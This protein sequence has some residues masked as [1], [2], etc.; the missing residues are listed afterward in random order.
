MSVRVKPKLYWLKKLAC[1]NIN[2]KKINKPTT[3]T[4]YNLRQKNFVKK[5]NKTTFHTP[6]YD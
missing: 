2:A 4:W 6:E 3:K 5:S 1:K